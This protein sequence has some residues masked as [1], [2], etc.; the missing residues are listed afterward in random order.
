MLGV[1]G[2][3]CGP[4]SFHPVIV[5]DVRQYQAAHD[6]IRDKTS[7]ALL[8]RQGWKE[9]QFDFLWRPIA[10]RTLSHVAILTVG[11]HEP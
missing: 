10:Q 8:W 2:M 9:Y 3:P 1:I 4:Q 11:E 5:R 7:V 6:S